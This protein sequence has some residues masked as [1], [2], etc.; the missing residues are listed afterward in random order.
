MR[1]LL[2]CDGPRC[3]GY[4]LGAAVFTVRARLETRS[5][6]TL[7]VRDLDLCAPCW[8]LAGRPDAPPST[9]DEIARA[10]ARMRG[11]RAA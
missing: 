9:K 4:E 3:P 1:L 8:R 5:R 11:E 7:A 6:G 2:A 10:E